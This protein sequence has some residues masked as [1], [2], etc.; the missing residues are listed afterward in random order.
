MR[1]TTTDGVRVVDLPS[2]SPAVGTRICAKNGHPPTRDF[3]GGRST[4][5]GVSAKPTLSHEFFVCRSPLLD[6]RPV[7]WL[8][9][10]GP[11]GL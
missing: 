7:A 5:S 3:R 2:S 8:V 10:L 6:E 1:P 4:H 11:P 9:F